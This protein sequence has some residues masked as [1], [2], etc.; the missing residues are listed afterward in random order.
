MD[1]ESFARLKEILLT[2]PRLP[3]GERSGYLAEV[4]AGDADLRNHV[5][6][7][8]AQD[9]QVPEILKTGGIAELLNTDPQ[10]GVSTPPTGSI[11]RMIGPYE[12]HGV[13]GEGGMG[14]VY[15]AVQTEPFRREVALKLVKRGM[16]T[17]QVVARF[18]TERQALALMDHTNIAT[19]F[20]AGANDLGRPYFVMELVRGVSITEYCDQRNLDV[21]RRLEIF[22]PVCR[23]V[24][25]AHQKGIIHRDLKPS[26][27]I[28][29]V[30]DGEPLPKI[31]DF[32]IAKAVDDRSRGGTL[33]T[34]E[35][36]LVGTPEYMSPEQTLGD[37]KGID[38]RTD[39]YSLGVILYEL[40]ARG[41]PYD[42]KGASVV[43]V[44][45][46]IREEPARRLRRGGSGT[47]RLDADVETIVLKALEK[48][49]DRRYS[50]AA[51]L[52]GD[53]ERYLASQ[54]ILARPPSAVYQLR[55]L[56]V[57]HRV[58]FAFLSAI[59]VLLLAFGVTMSFMF[60]KQRR[61]YVRAEREAQKAAEI[62]TFLREM[63]SSVAPDEMGREVTVREV[64]DESATKIGSA[65]ADEPEVQAAVQHTIGKTYQALGLTEKAEPHLRA[66]LATEQG[67]HGFLHPD[68]VAVIEDLGELLVETEKMA[69]A[70][71]LMRLSLASR[72]ALHGDEDHRLA[73][74]L[75]KLADI[76][77]FNASPAEAESLYREALAIRQRAL[78]DTAQDVG[79]SMNDFAV[80]LWGRGRY[81]E[82]E[83]LYR[84]ALE[85][86]KAAY[87]DDHP[88]ISTMTDN[89]AL[90]LVCRGKYS[91]AEP[92]HRA[93]LEGRRRFL[94][95]EH[96]FVAISLCN[97]SLCLECLSRYAEAEELMRESLRMIRA[98][99]GEDHQRTNI[100]RL[101]LGR[102]LLM[103]GRYSEA[104]ELLNR[105][106]TSRKRIFGKESP[107][108]SHPRLW[109]ASL[110]METGRAAQAEPMLRE[111]LKALKA[112]FPADYSVIGTTEN[113][114]A[115]CLAVLGQAE[116]AERLLSLSRAKIEK[117]PLYAKRLAL[118]RTAELYASWGR[119]DEAEFYSSQL[120]E[121][122]QTR[123]TEPSTP[124]DLALPPAGAVAAGSPR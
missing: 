46:V 91:E 124:S 17:E 40:L 21:K 71:S 54:P 12:I 18:A 69:E 108:L 77:K 43:D 114:L 1:P 31:I 70:E 23:A 14:I 6:A 7:I 76:A 15:R 92:L 67:I 30:R 5:D 95:E 33:L 88:D 74:S 48:E 10:T 28:V 110:W 3:N 8:L 105:A 45:R 61:E 4:C 97:L 52:A 41:L 65:L 51:A 113:T 82:A 22:L 68:A 103:R 56:V 25:H 37:P 60:E 117:A 26:N 116:E 72:R 39:I 73:R 100:A 36:Q 102:I 66:A 35:G 62:S 44:A 118:Q 34:R 96:P 98:Y 119:P 53:I 42:T 101:N 78:G 115:R 29:T 106:I 104:E 2:L 47:R 109:L 80:F 49:P 59:M 63:L 112:H 79:S 57:R 121:G 89:L 58:L 32:G 107:S 93:A 55:K 84:R 20:D 11:P 120:T 75:T 123:T 38:P 122:G 87:G 16:D 81:E 64:L 24:Q 27:I 111:V 83:P 85:I 13:L 94:G 50:S 9:A 19:V 86:R 90:L 99:H